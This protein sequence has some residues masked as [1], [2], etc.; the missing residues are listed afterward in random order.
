MHSRLWLR[1]SRSHSKQPVFGKQGGSQSFETPAVVVLQM[2]AV[3]RR[4]L[5]WR[6]HRCRGVLRRLRRGVLPLPHR[7]EGRH[8]LR[9]GCFG[10]GPCA[11][12]RPIFRPL[13]QHR[14]I[15]GLFVRR[16]NPTCLHPD[17]GL[18][19]RLLGHRRLELHRLELHRLELCRL[20]Q[21][22]VRCAGRRSG[23]LALRLTWPSCQHQCRL[24]PFELRRT[25]LNHLAPFGRRPNRQ[26]PQ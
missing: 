21:N 26:P 22:P 6:R 8:F 4:Q 20:V 23:R 3:S 15:R 16:W 17:H 7:E 19:A 25:R 18:L 24:D 14:I 2:K 11:H 12:R 1:I 9:L 5:R 13:P 10:R